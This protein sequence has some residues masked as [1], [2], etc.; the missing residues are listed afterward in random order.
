MRVTCLWIAVNLETCP[1]ICV[2]F[3]EIWM[4]PLFCNQLPNSLLNIK[5]R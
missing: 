2:P 5:L 1:L 3:H 4:F